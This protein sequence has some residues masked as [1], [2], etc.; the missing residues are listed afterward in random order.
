MKKLIGLGMMIVFFLFSTI[1]WADSET[2]G[3]DANIE[4]DLVGYY[5]YRAERVGDHSTAWKRIATIPKGSTTYTDDTIVG[6]LNYTW[7]VTAYNSGGQES[8]VSNMVE[9][10]DRTPPMTLQNLKKQ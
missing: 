6:G 1:C 2:L 7:Q 4:A 5:L 10:Y 9:R 8:F 3:W